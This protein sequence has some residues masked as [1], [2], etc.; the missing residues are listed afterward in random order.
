MDRT[1]FDTHL[2]CLQLV[3]NPKGAMKSFSERTK[4]TPPSTA[5]H[6][7]DRS[8]ANGYSVKYIPENRETLVKHNI[9]CLEKLELLPLNDERDMVGVDEPQKDNNNP[10]STKE[11]NEEDN[12]QQ[13]KGDGKP[14]DEDEEDQME[15]DEDA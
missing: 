5:K 13:N 1:P 8:L 6:E 15:N 14:E 10:I 4:K 9:F 3:A 11:S 7:Y 12:S 2:Y